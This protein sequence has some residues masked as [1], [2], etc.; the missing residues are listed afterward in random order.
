MPN[1]S[2]WY[3]TYPALEFS[4]PLGGDYWTLETRVTFFLLDGVQGRAFALVVYLDP[5]RDRETA[6]VVERSKE[7]RFTNRLSVSLLDQGRQSVVNDQCLAA[8][9][10]VGVP[11]F[12]YTFRI[13]RADTVLRVAVREEGTPFTEVLRASLRGDLRGKQQLLGLTGS[14]WFVPAGSY[15]D[16]DYVRFSQG[17]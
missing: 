17:N 12:T 5:S 6:L 3:W 1:F 7:V 13:S 16:W 14:S 11:R 8:A 10:T 2:G 9:D 15:A 4:R